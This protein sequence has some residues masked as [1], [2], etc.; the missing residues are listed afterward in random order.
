M[1]CM[2]THVTMLTIISVQN[3]S[4][5]LKN[6]VSGYSRLAFL[7]WLL[8]WLHEGTTLSDDDEQMMHQSSSYT[9]DFE[10]NPLWQSFAVYYK[11]FT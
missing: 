1:G 4:G 7:R 3:V 6:M 8:L 11:H 2:H 10:M 9:N 5:C